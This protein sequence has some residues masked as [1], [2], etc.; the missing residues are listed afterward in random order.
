MAVN[1]ANTAKCR[2]KKCLY[3][4]SPAGYVGVVFNRCCGDGDPVQSDFLTNLTRLDQNIGAFMSGPSRWRPTV[5]KQSE[6]AA[7]K[8]SH[9]NVFT[10]GKMKM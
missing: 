9:G 2:C 3:L 6:D 8:T 5:L 4:K 1:K 7:G 10:G